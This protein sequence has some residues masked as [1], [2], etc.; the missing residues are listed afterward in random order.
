MLKGRVK[1]T[2][3]SDQVLFNLRILKL[4]VQQIWKSEYFK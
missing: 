1:Y 2:A 3:Y 4:H